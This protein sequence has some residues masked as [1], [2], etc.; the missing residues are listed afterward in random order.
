M[1][2]KHEIC[3]QWHHVIDVA[4]T[5]LEAAGLPEPRIVNGTPQTPIQGVSMLSSFNDAK[6]PE[7]HL[8][9]YFEMFGNRGVY[10]EGWLAGTVHRAPWETKVR[11][12][13]RMTS[14]AVRYKIRLQPNDLASKNPEKLH[15]MQAIFMRE[16][17]ANH[18]LPIDDRLFERANPEL[19]GRP[20]LMAG[21]KSLTVYDGMF[22]IPENAFIYVKNSSFSIT[23]DV[24]VP[25][26]PANGWSHR[27]A[28]SAGGAFTSRMASRP[29]T[30]ISWG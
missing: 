10:S 17:I 8:T 3:W 6:A 9:Q 5:I 2:A 15:E 29:T 23:A 16:A 21:R 30:T 14:G 27:V 4:P 28:A 25:D 19:A 7:N 13:S 11:R 24:I 12:R 20:D 1:Q 22:S 18:V 26:Q